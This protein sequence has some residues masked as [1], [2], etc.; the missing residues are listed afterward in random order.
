MIAA[1]PVCH[2]CGLP[3]E[4]AVRRGDWAFCCSACDLAHQIIQEAGGEAYYQFRERAPL[5]RPQ[6]TDPLPWD[7][8]AFQAAFVRTTPDG[9]EV[10]LILDG[11]H[12][13]ACIWVI[14]KV[15]G[16]VKGVQEVK[17]H[18][19]ASRLHLSYRDLPLSHLTRTLEQLGYSPSPYNPANLEAP[20]RRQDQAMLARLVTAGF[21]TLAL[22]FLTEPI[23]FSQFAPE[24]IHLRRLFEWSQALVA[25]PIAW[26]SIWPFL[27]GAW[28]GLK[29]RTFTMD[30]TVTLGAFV[31]WL[32]S[33]IGL[34]TNREHLYF[35]SL[36]M[37]LFLILLGRTL[38]ARAKRQAFSTSEQLLKLGGLLARRIQAGETQLISPL[39]LAPGDLVEL[40]PGDKVP[41]DGIIETGDT[42]LNESM[43]T[44]EARPV[45][46]RPGDP[47]T[48]GTHNLDG[49]VRFRV[50]RS[51]GATTLAQIVRLVEESDSHKAPIQR[52]ADQV[53]HVFVWIIL[54]IASLTFLFTLSQGLDTAVTRAVAVL[55]VTCPC[56]L[57]LAIPAALVLGTSAAIQRGVLI[58]KGE[59]LETLP[60]IARVYLDKTGTLTTGQ[61]TV[62]AWHPAPGVSVCT[63]KE[64]AKA[65]ESGSEHPLAVA[66]RQAADTGTDLPTSGFQAFPGLGV[67]AEVAGSKGWAGNLNFVKQHVPVPDASA[68]EA[69]HENRLGHTV[70]A[71]AHAGHFL[72][73]VAIGDRIRPDARDVVK[74]LREQGIE[75]AMVTGD[76]PAAAWAIAR[77]LGITTV[78][79]GLLPQDKQKLVAE[80]D[81]PVAFVGDGLNDAPALA[82]ATVGLAVASGNDLSQDAAGIVLLQ[83]RLQGLADALAVARAT[84][85]II[86]QNLGWALIYN[87][88]AIPMAVMGWVTPLMAAVIMPLSSLVVIANALKL[89]WRAA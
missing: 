35:D 6:T 24:E 68:L 7:D 63:L 37:F 16:R 62:Q 82:A 44:G 11:L 18:Y 29:V 86:R 42:R 12:C 87:M 36:V 78:H 33:T 76:T 75:L 72:G 31:T 85:R 5:A 26:Y 25:T 67:T 71:I 13:P 89:K 2:H 27:K 69:L 50:T 54:A 10:D 59:A 17:V 56:A 47:V 15:L 41:A 45:H 14:E 83:P 73:L 74:N 20:A 19:T 32:Y 70:V 61:M 38:E 4:R 49:T 60:R 51:G 28:T 46:R 65:L 66:I 3:I 43:L 55:I 88:I 40:L 79:A 48:A 34:F 9:H 23:Y 39:S 80:S 52:L 84:R 77:E 1:P 30:F 58:K 21:G 64:T 8:P 57:G 22:M 81:L 53:S